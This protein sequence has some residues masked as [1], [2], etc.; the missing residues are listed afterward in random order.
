VGLWAHPLA[1]RLLLGRLDLW[2]G[3][4]EGVHLCLGHLVV[5]VVGV[6]SVELFV[7]KEGAY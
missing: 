7:C 1:D 2:E 3:R 5:L 6:L 4:R